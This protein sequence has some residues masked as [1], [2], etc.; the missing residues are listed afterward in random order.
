MFL[1]PLAIPSNL[2]GH[3]PGKHL[4]ETFYILETFKVFGSGTG[5]TS[6][7]IAINREISE[8]IGKKRGVKKTLKNGFTSI[9]VKIKSSGYFFRASRKKIML[10]HP[11]PHYVWY[12]SAGGR[13]GALYGGSV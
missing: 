4:T 6:N 2:H 5:K 1:T 7:K 12:L 3:L 13:R 11:T 9:L 8:K 10:P